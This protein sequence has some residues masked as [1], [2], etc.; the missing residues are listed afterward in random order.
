MLASLKKE[1]DRRFAGLA[2]CRFGTSA[3]LSDSFKGLVTMLSDSFKGLV[4]DE[5]T[6]E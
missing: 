5:N 1:E 6:R 4:I 3:M 2:T